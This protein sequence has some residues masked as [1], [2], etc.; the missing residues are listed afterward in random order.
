M[1]ILAVADVHRDETHVAMF[2]ETLA[3]ERPDVVVAAGDLGHCHREAEKLIEAIEASGLPFLFV[4]GNHEREPHAHERLRCNPRAVWLD[5][6]V[7]LHDGVV[8]LGI[9]YAEAACIGRSRGIEIRPRLAALVK[10]FDELAPEIRDS[11]PRVLVTHEP[12]RAWH[13]DGNKHIDLFAR[14]HGI[15]TIICGHLHVRQP[16]VRETEHFKV[17]NPGPMGMMV[18]V[19]A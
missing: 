7:V 6:Q 19:L 18:E 8:F 15:E 4:T 2:L 5:E 17:I 16:S 11:A 1:R 9:G 12:P 14:Q 13:R 3:R 10:Q